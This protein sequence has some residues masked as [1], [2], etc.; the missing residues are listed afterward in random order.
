MR[1]G[2]QNEE[3][4]L[5]VRGICLLIQAN[6]WTLCGGP[7]VLVY[8]AFRCILT[9]LNREI[10]YLTVTAKKKYSLVNSLRM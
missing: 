9:A 4:W 10:S 6:R 5:R 7:T 8:K 2:P 3:K 1:K